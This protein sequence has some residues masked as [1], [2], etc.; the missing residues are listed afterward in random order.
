MSFM[1]K[2]WDWKNEFGSIITDQL[3]KLGASCDWER[4]R[5]TL[6]K[7]FQQLY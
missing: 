3:K 4:E 5:F 7:D 6:M 2:A 1:E